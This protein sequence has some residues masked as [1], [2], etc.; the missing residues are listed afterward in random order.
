MQQLRDL[1]NPHIDFD[2]CIKQLKNP[3]NEFLR[4]YMGKVRN[5][6]KT[7]EG[8]AKMSNP[9]FLGLVILR[10]KEL[11][12][13]F[14]PEEKLRGLYVSVIN[15]LV[16]EDDNRK[17][18]VENGVISLILDLMGQ[19]GPN[20]ERKVLVKILCFIAEDVWY[21]SEIINYLNNKYPTSNELEN[22]KNKILDDPLDINEREFFLDI[23]KFTDLTLEAYKP[24][25]SFL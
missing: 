9:E 18:M 3:D 5:Y 1:Q 4:T 22:W 14:G 21:R 11:V 17:I 20:I 23:L 10:L 15:N 12:V 13:N 24:G 6:I 8:K 2:L 7:E 19:L 16:D 25:K